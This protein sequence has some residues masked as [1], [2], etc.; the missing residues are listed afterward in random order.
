MIKVY[1][2]LCA[3]G[4]RNEIFSEQ[5]HV[6]QDCPDCGAPAHRTI[7][8]PRFQLEGVSGDFPGA[9]MQWEKKRAQKMAVQERKLRDHGD[10]GWT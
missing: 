1:D 9:A 5:H 6:V 3:A 2:Y 7:S 8:A 4:H 10:E